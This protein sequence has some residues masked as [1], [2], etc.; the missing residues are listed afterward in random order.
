M[1]KRKQAAPPSLHSA[2]VIDNSSLVI[3][4]K[5]IVTKASK[6]VVIKTVISLGSA[7]STAS[8]VFGLVNWRISQGRLQTQRIL[9]LHRFWT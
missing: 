8:A 2:S 6:V 3:V 5:I 4:I 9:L 7:G 1:G